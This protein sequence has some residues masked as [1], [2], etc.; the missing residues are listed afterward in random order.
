MTGWRGVFPAITT[1]FKSDQSIDMAA[2]AAS[3]ERQI[4]AGVNGI[5]MCG[6][7]SEASTLD[8]EEKR[9]MVKLA[10]DTAKGRVPVLAGLGLFLVVNVVRKLGGAVEATNAAIGGAV[11]TLRLP[12]ASLSPWS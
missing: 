6:S 9:S 3:I 11:V 7:L 1:Q 10:L 5:I 4:K 8:G 2:T 12:L